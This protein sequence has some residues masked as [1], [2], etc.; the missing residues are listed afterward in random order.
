M[1]S[2]VYVTVVS[3]QCHKE[4]SPNLSVA[5]ASMDSYKLCI[6]ELISW[7][8]GLRSVIERTETIPYSILDFDPG[9]GRGRCCS[10]LV[11]VMTKVPRLKS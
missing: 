9:V 11:R 5:S 6:I 4:R 3:Q 8:G 2:P 10:G 1:D 7:A